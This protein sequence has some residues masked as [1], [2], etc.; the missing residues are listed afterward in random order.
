MLIKTYKVVRESFVK[1][2]SSAFFEGKT[3]TALKDL[4]NLGGDKIGKGCPVTILGKNSD[5]KTYL[6]V[7]F[8]NTLIYGVSY[9]DLELVK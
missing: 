9:D 4:K 7:Q 8:G 2:S 1:K 6:D 5:R 3:A